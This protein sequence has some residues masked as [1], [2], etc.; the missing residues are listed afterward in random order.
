MEQH[1]SKSSSPRTRKKWVALLLSITMVLSLPLPAITAAE[2][3][4]QTQQAQEETV[5]TDQTNAASQ[6]EAQAPDLEEQPEQVQAGEEL[7]QEGQEG[8]ATEELPVEEQEATEAE[9]LQLK[10]LIAD[11]PT[12]AE[13][14][15]NDYILYFVN[16][17]DTTPA[18]AE[19]GDKLGLFASSTEQS[20]GADSVTGKQ[21]GLRTTTTS[22]STS[23]ASSKTGTL[24]YYTGSQTR[25]KAIQY[26][27]ELPE[28]KYDVTFGF[29]N[30][31]SDRSVNLIAEGQ[32]LSGDYAIGS[33]VLREF[34]YRGLSVTDGTL[35][36][37]VQGPATG[38]PNQW[39]DPLINYIII[40][41]HN[42]MEYSQL[43]DMINS[44]GALANNPDY[45]V[46]S[47]QALKKVLADAQQFLDTAQQNNTDVLTVQNE[48][49][50]WRSSILKAQGALEA[51]PVYSSFRPGEV[52]KDT[53][54]APIQAHGGGILYD[55]NTQTYYWYGEDKT[56]GYSPTLGVHVYSSKDLY[57]WKD[58][59]IALTAIKSMEEFESDPLISKLYDGRADKDD[60]YNDIG[61]TR[62]LERPKVIYNDK[63]KKYVMWLHTDGPST[64]SNANYAKAEAGYAL[65]DS[66]TGPFVY[67]KSERLDRAPADAEYNGQ[68]NQPGM[69]RDMTLYKDDDGTAY[70]I[71]SSEE[72][73]TMYI[74]KLNDAYTDVTGWH[75]DGKEERD[76]EYKAVYGEDYVRVFPGA[77]REA[78]AVF[79]Y[80]GKYYMITSGATGWSP[81][82]A[83]YT[84]ADSLFG[85][86]QPM[87]DPSIGPLASTTHG[88]QSTYVIPV[89]PANGKFVY[90]GDRW[91][92]SDLG[93]SRY[94]WLPLEFGPNNQLMLKWYDEWQLPLLDSMGSIE[95]VST[96]PASVQVG[97]PPVLPAQ[98]RIKKGQGGSEQL[99]A[100]NW[101]LDA[102]SFNKPGRVTVRGVLPEMANKE[103]SIAMDVV[104]YNTVYFVDS[105]GAPTTD[106]GSATE[107]A[108]WLKLMGD[109]VLNAGTPDQQYNPAAGQ[110]WGYVGD[111][112]NTSGSASDDIFA[113]LRYLTSNAGDDLSYSFDVEDGVYS[114]YV[115]LYDPWS[116]WS[117]GKRKADIIINEQKVHE[118]YTFTS[119]KDV[120]DFRNLTVEGGKLDVTVRRSPLAGASSSD[121]QISWIM[122]SREK[123]AQ[124]LADGLVIAAPALGATELT[125]PEMPAGY[126]LEITG[127]SQPK[128]ISV[129]GKITQP[130][131]N[132]E[133]ELTLVVTRQLDNSTGTVTRKVVVPSKQAPYYPS[134]GTSGSTP[135][136]GTD[137]PG[138]AGTGTEG[139]APGNQAGAIVID[140]PSISEHTATVTLTPEAVE[141][142]WESSSTAVLDR[143]GQ[144]QA[145]SWIVKL[146]VATLGKPADG[147][148]L[149][150]K[151]DLG[152]VTLP[153]G[154]LAGMANSSAEYVDLQIA[155]V[156]GT[157]ATD[158]P[159]FE[160]KL[161]MD[162]KPVEPG[163]TT[164]QLT[165][166]LPYKLAAGEQAAPLVAGQLND[167]GE[168]TPL[169]SS[170][171]DA[172]TGTLTFLADGPGSYSVIYNNRN[173]ND[174]SNYSWAGTAVDALAAR[175]IINGV[176]A[177]DFSP[178]AQVTRGDFLLMLTRALDLR[179]GKSGTAFADVAATDYWHDAIM[180]AR[181]LGIAG[182]KGDNRFDPSGEITREDMF[183]M[184]YRALAAAG[185]PVV[186][187]ADQLG[188]FSDA[189][190]ISSYASEGTAAL[191]HSG[192]VNGSG[193]KLNPQGVA[194]RAEVAA[195]IYRLT[196]AVY[197]DGASN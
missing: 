45:S 147:K 68:P 96:L 155:P 129:D 34:V 37:A 1:Q 36:V 16:A 17:G 8:Q 168:A 172:K 47:V 154:W 50:T 176:S 178:A 24:R 158:K 181:E 11:G 60:I 134:T 46:Y 161:Q 184:T 22:T 145:S 40:R 106:D 121:P 140:A 141:K 162:G 156:A 128:V 152:V 15:A 74:S 132:T 52:W 27:F 165:V 66:P 73:M 192:I 197:G 190:A 75:K 35:N 146:P 160:L 23:D 26:D 139:T 133:V 171:Y 136:T 179:A 125:L 13:L 53:N 166:T 188:G 186:G 95:I 64:T 138:N 119:A 10:A 80:N 82:P 123:S 79:K 100:V 62:V 92:E 191:I 90:M 167:A 33:K 19:S 183:V 43:Q 110:T 137:G 59:G 115:G 143:S 77:Q 163:Q 54:G 91:K 18:T 14:E 127:T 86:W 187:A 84:V 9:P 7:D 157:D 3:A 150:I 87:R 118:T 49:Y 193:G 31:W 51:A 55:E 97:K 94:I 76:A 70:I 122:V 108:A 83:R 58:E 69:A 85:T 182:G 151:T 116:Q 112:T 169:V 32:N 20:F 174:M 72:N 98:I 42:V 28:G 196:Q 38:T 175:G 117:N 173:F 149:Q 41:K 124:E 153:A 180:T 102:A 170:R 103:I 114:V 109:S 111:A 12:E 81:N 71:Y 130:S 194:I 126:S 159:T 48:L 6:E 63:T 4:A 148:Q 104:P 30:P 144:D 67:G 113:N 57:N 135:G 101:T 89:D 195:M 25:D 164:G 93:D 78:P 105:G 2:P 99:T 185:K 131:R 61:S 65:S 177:T 56:T 5:S 142:A 44:A 189:T 107:Y 29:F 88:S 39:N 120:L 21:W